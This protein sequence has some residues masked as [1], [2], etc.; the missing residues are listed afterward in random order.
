[1]STIVKVGFVSHSYG[2]DL[3]SLAISEGTLSKNRKF[4]LKFFY[5]AGSNLDFWIETWPQVLHD[6]FDYSPD[7]V[8]VAIGGNSIQHNVRVKA[9]KEKFEIFFTIIK[10]NLPNCK[11][12]PVQVELRFLR[13]ANRFGTPPEAR[14]RAIR[15]KVNKVLQQ[16][17]IRDFMCN[18]A[19]KNRLDDKKYYKSDLIHMNQEG[20]N[21]YLRYVIKTIKYICDK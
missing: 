8:F 9:L 11:L 5:K 19:G 21:K 13:F 14:Y 16:S 18:I 20:L 1:M 3:E 4:Q 12:V 17:N 2:R 10:N 7:I 6:L 15:N